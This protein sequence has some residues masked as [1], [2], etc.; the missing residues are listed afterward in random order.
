MVAQ[1]ITFDQIKS[2]LDARYTLHYVDRDSSLTDHLDK[3]GTTI[4]TQDY[5]PID[6]LVDEWFRD[7]DYGLDTALD[8]LK[9]KIEST[10]D[11]EDAEDLIEKYR[12]DIIEVIYDRD[13]STPL[14][15]LIRNT[16]DAVAFYDTDLYL[17][18]PYDQS[19]VAESLKEIKRLLKIKLKDVTHD[20]KLEEM[21]VNASYGGRLVVYFNP[22]KDDLTALMQLGD[23]NCI[24]FRNPTL[25]II[26]TMNGS[27]YN[28]TLDGFHFSLPLNPQ[29]FFFDKEIKYNYTY[30]VC[31]M[32]SNWCQSTSISFARKRYR[33]KESKVNDLTAQLE[34]ERIYKETFQKGKCTYGDK[35]PYRHRNVVYQNTP[36][37]CGTKCQ[38]CGMF[39]ID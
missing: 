21:I 28:V 11:L 12:D 20:K 25:A 16:R 14:D 5:E 32:Y 10:F 22:D 7:D 33:K 6:T 13:D 18:E 8:E 19:T 9:D 35:D 38:D 37:M 1:E 24:E 31:G 4:R 17:G 23:K 34:Q 39:W 15:D 2:L 29:N 27:G 3:L 30:A 26:D 36:P